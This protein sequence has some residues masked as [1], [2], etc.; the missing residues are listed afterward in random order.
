MH[1]G[2]GDDEDFAAYV[3]ARRAAHVRAVVALGSPPGHATALTD[4]ALARA[5]AEWR[6]LRE[7]ADP[8]VEVWRL[9]LEV[10]AED[11][12]RWWHSEPATPAPGLDRLTPVRRT[13]LVL[14]AVA[15]LDDAALVELTGEWPRPGDPRTEDLSQEA[16][17]LAAGVEVTPRAAGAVAAVPRG[18]RV[19]RRVLV[20]GVLLAV[21]VGLGTWQAAGPGGPDPDAGGLG[22][23]PVRAV[24]NS[25]PTAWAAAGELVVDDSA[26]T[27]PGV[28]RLVRVRGAVVYSDGSGR[29]VR[30]DATGE[31]LQL[32]TSAPGAALVVERERAWVAWTDVAGTELVVADVRTG[33]E[34]ARH[35]L[36]P[37]PPAPGPLNLEGPTLYYVDGSGSHTWD[38]LADPDGQAGDPPEGPGPA[39]LLDVDGLTTVVQVGERRIR[40]DG[41]FAPARTRRGVGAQL[42]PGGGYVLTRTGPDPRA[43]VRVYETASGRSRR[44]GIGAEE[45]ALDAVFSTTGAITYVVGDADQVA[46]AG[47]FRRLSG[48]RGWLLRTCFIRSG[49]CV[50]HLRVSSADGEPVLAR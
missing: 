13:C 4:R 10:R 17:D 34:L 41:P 7:S 44:T 2:A 6:V 30:T 42:S 39:G 35:G 47:E 21:V 31:R 25:V 5:R 9:L 8:G 43:P 50:D 16:R 12:T 33:E 20:G 38:P 24:R 23:V 40:F 19:P 11:T 1:G 48:A 45:I 22:P 37:G 28:R 36:D 3:A 26:L 14:A 27:L 18:R 49:T 29:V 32:G 15:G 46:A